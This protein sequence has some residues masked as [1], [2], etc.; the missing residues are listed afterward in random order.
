LKILLFH[1]VPLPP[2]DYGGVERVVLWLAEGLRD[3]GHSVTIA[4]LE[5]SQVPPGVSFLPVPIGQRSAEK[6]IGRI[7]AGTDVV[8]FQ[9]PPESGFFR[10]GAPPA[11]TTIHGNGKPGEVFSQNMVFLSRDHASRH[12]S[13]TFVYNGINPSE[14]GLADALGTSKQRDRPLFLSKTTLRTKNLEG[15]LEIAA[16]AEKKLTIAGGNRPL[17]LRLLAMLSGAKWVGPV[18][19]VEKAKRLAESSS[20]LFPVLW[21][22]P[23]GLVMIEALMSGTPIVGSRRGSIPEL[24]G[25]D[26]GF[27]LDLPIDAN[28]A[29]GFARWSDA[30]HSAQKLDPAVLRK[31]A[32]DRFSHHRMAESYLDVY[33]RVI[34]GDRL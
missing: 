29:E 1:P 5:G 10:E 23:F 2:K 16:K 20:L 18:S 11:L 13:Q 14:F 32:I 17:K 31:G 21:D 4:A 28:D 33:K 8:H 7:P 9:A 24:V 22:E 27:V 25:A 3:F 12:G 6:L 26:S 15:A 19:G 30:L 34:R